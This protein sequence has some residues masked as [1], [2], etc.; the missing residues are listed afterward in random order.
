M[1]K[2]YIVPQV[3]TVEL[4]NPQPVC[5]S[6]ERAQLW[7]GDE[8]EDGPAPDAAESAGYRSTLWN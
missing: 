2:K 1:K 5:S 7:V 8:Q 6:I 3:V 4:E